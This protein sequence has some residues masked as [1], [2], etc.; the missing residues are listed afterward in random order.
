MKKNYDLSLVT[1]AKLGFINFDGEFKQ[2]SP[3]LAKDLAQTSWPMS[4]NRTKIEQSV[5]PNLLDLV[6]PQDRQIVLSA[7][8]QLKSGEVELSFEV[9][10][11]SE[12]E[13]HYPK[14]LLWQATAV[15]EQQGFYA[16]VTDISVYKQSAIQPPSE[17]SKSCEKCQADTVF[18]RYAL[19]LEVG[20]TGVWD[21]KI[22]TNEIHLDAYLKTLLG[23]TD[24]KS[25][26]S[27]EAWM[28]LVHPADV[29]RLRQAS[30]DYLLQRRPQL[31]EEY[32]LLDKQGQIRWMIVRGTALRD[33]QGHAYRL[34]GTNT[35]I[36]ER[37]QVEHQLQEQERLL[38]GVAQVTHTLLTMSDDDQAI[39]TA[40]AILGHITASDRA[41]IFENSLI[42]ET[43]EKIINQNFTW[44]NEKYKPYNTPYKLK[45]VSYAHY[46]PGWYEILEKH[47]HIAG[48]TQDFSNPVRAL[49]ESYQVISILIVPI[50]FNGQ[51][52]GLI[53]LDDC[54]HERQWS[55]YEIFVLKVIGDSIRGTLAQKHFKNSLRQSEVKFRSIIE[56]NR[57]AIII[58]DNKRIIR[59]VNPAAEN[60]YQAP[61]GTLIGTTFE[62]HFEKVANQTEFKFIDYQ[63]YH[64]VG[65]LQLS[66]IEW[67]GEKLTIASL[68]DVTARKQAEEALRQSEKRLTTVTSNLPVILFSL[69][70]DGI[71]TLLRG[72][73]L[74]TFAL[75]E[76]E[77]VGQSI[78][79]L[80]RNEPSIVENARRALTG[81]FFTSELSYREMILE[82][83]YSPLLNREGHFIGTLALATDIT[84]RR[85]VEIELQRAKE[86]AEAANRLKSM[87]LAAMSHEIRTPMNGVLGMTKLL[88]NTSLTRQQHHYVKMINNSGQVLLTVINDILDFS[89]IEAGQGLTLQIIEFDL[90]ALIEEMVNL[91]AATAQGQGLEILCQLPPSF[92]KFLQGDPNRL[93]QILN[94]LLGNAIKFTP[95]GQVLLRV[96]LKSETTTRVV[97]GFEVIDTGIGISSH[98]RNR[99]F[100]IYFRSEN[101]NI[102]YHGTGLG[103]FI[104]RQLVYKMDGEIDVESQPGQG[105]TFWFRLPLEKTRDRLLKTKLSKTDNESQKTETLRGLNLL[106]V[107]DNAT[108]R[109]ILFEETRVW[110]ME[111]QV[112]STSKSAWRRLGE[113]VEKGKPFQLV[114]LD[115]EM[116]ELED[117]LALWQKIKTDSRFAKLM[118]VMMTTLQNSLE[119]SVI[120][121]L[122][123]YLNKPI[124][125]T[126]LLK[127]LLNLVT[128]QPFKVEED[129]IILVDQKP[130]PSWRVLLAEDNLINQEVTREML[131]QLRCSVHVVPNGL[132][133]LKAIEQQSF[134]L[135][136]MDCNMPELDGFATS[137]KI[138]EQEINHDQPRIPIIALTADVMP[139]TRERC[140]AVGMDDYLTKPIIF[141]NLKQILETWLEKNSPQEEQI[142]LRSQLELENSNLKTDAEPDEPINFEVFKKMRRSLQSQQINEFIDLYLRELPVYLTT[143]QQAIVSQDGEA[144]FLAAHK[145]KGASATLGVQRVAALC[146]TLEKMG[147]DRTF[148]TATRQF[149]QIKAECDRAKTILEKAKSGTQS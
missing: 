34:V 80:Y 68:R 65:E 137:R 117:G 31:E 28:A 88:R 101:S 95:K 3:I 96:S 108:C 124:L 7:L 30:R 111:V 74:A 147:Y 126:E 149:V 77:L 42:P 107:D 21:W 63:G 13:N 73:G 109:Q 4:G 105:S 78:F 134:D 127:C 120:K 69:N 143:L 56:N 10:C 9:R 90:Q 51:F 82:I 38:R 98:E 113:A 33:E 93:R 85:Q 102:R 55:E 20:K 146:Q 6:E 84:E 61:S 18:D 58:F 17:L 35:D 139:T 110:Q 46:L 22:D 97:L 23:L 12:E 71:F 14:W 89:K 94:N 91:F 129:S 148:E 104:S 29:K 116:P 44:V 5:W 72:K 11:Q 32:R 75:Q 41:Y 60:L 130:T 57:D 140:L 138:R 125:R 79:E 86:A 118:V 141:E 123:G 37:K 47:K 106:I 145:F 135:I 8:S 92:P 2:I 16:Q 122:A 114:L 25:H 40:L 128:T 19:A 24:L 83:K 26:H 112:A 15:P 87:F 48:L 45:N 36:T 67:E 54:H 59:F 99:L 121:Q 144:L 66:D 76:D 70:Q 103:L 100:Q 133:A 115:A 64:H 62:A 132:E 1:W 49:L 81:E 50:H 119:P 136:V 39:R 43:K 131:V 53:G 52:W 142:Q 27:L